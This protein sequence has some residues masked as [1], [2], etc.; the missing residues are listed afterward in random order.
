MSVEARNNITIVLIYY[1]IN[2]TNNI[3][4]IKYY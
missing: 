3:N 1:N 2:N 4:N